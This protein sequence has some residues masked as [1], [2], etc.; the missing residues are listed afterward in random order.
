MSETCKD[1]RYFKPLNGALGACYRYAPRPHLH[2]V[3]ALMPN[4]IPERPAGTIVFRPATTESD[5]CGEFVAKPA[6]DGGGYVN[7]PQPPIG[8][9]NE[10]A[11]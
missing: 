3:E 9:S 11:Y 10:D 1:C 2:V 5:W 7:E 4:V 6:F 8:F